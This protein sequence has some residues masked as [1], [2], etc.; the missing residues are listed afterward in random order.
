MDRVLTEPTAVLQRISASKRGSNK[1]T[2]TSQEAALL[3]SVKFYTTEA[4]T[5]AKPIM[6]RRG[7]VPIWIRLNGRFKA[8]A[9]KAQVYLDM[10]KGRR[11]YYYSLDISKKVFAKGATDSQF[12][13]DT[14]YHEV[15][16][17]LEWEVHRA[18]GHGPN[19][20]RIMRLLG[21]EPYVYCYAEDF[22][23]VGYPI[24]FSEW[25]K[26]PESAYEETVPHADRRSLTKKELGL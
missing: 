22:A 11:E 4:L 7:P 26:K 14:V 6:K 2:F 13:I 20:Q 21:K 17:I 9:G 12:L 10:S 5:K 24:E 19:W 16:H 25:M 23:S 3:E 8:T 15:A 18:L 1:S